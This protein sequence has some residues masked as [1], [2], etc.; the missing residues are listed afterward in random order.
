LQSGEASSSAA[1]Q[2][3]HSSQT[4]RVEAVKVGRGLVASGGRE[5]FAVFRD[6]LAVPLLQLVVR[7]SYSPP[8][9]ALA[10]EAARHIVL[11]MMEQVRFVCMS[12]AL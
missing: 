8:D 3:P 7:S 10:E 12:V 4:A 5:V 6:V 2:P 1:P 11:P 9:L